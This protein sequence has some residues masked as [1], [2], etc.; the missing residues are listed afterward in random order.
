MAFRYI[1]LLVATVFLIVASSSP[2]VAA[3][4]QE[5]LALDIAPYHNTSDVD[6][7]ISCGDIG[8]S[9][10]F[11]G[12]CDWALCSPYN[13]KCHADVPWSRD[14]LAPPTYKNEDARIAVGETISFEV[15]RRHNGGQFKGWLYQLEGVSRRG[16]T[17]LG[18]T[19][20]RNQRAI[21]HIVQADREATAWLLYQID[22]F[23]INGDLEVSVALKL[24]PKYSHFID[25]DKDK[26]K[27]TQLNFVKGMFGDDKQSYHAL[28]FGTTMR[29]E[30]KSALNIDEDGEGNV[31]DAG[32]T[33]YLQVIRE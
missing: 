12:C 33:A 4:D 3:V 23:Y 9:C 31:K 20:D 10:V 28:W 2:N 17:E 13:Y 30:R 25:S 1:S 18:V 14:Q 27:A 16:W 24:L 26:S 19:T 7:V 22:W 32:Y 5:P 6:A 8:D 15:Y 11:V 21:F 29:A